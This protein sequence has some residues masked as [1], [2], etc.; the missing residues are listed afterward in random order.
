[1][2]DSAL[3]ARPLIL[4]DFSAELGSSERAYWS[5]W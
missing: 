4:S 3:K 2:L 1:M 5:L